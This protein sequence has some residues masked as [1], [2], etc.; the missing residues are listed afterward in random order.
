[1]DKISDLH[2]PIREYIINEILENYI[3]TKILNEKSKLESKI[4][5]ID[6]DEN[7]SEYNKYINELTEINENIK[8]IDKNKSK[9]YNNLT[10]RRIV[11]NIN[12]ANEVITKSKESFN[13][14]IKN[15]VELLTNNNEESD[16]VIQHLK[17]VKNKLG[18]FISIVPD[19]SNNKDDDVKDDTNSAKDEIDNIENELDDLKYHDSYDDIDLLEQSLNK[20]KEHNN[21]DI[22][23][24]ANILLRKLNK[25]KKN[26]K[27]K[28]NKKSEK[29]IK[30]NDSDSSLN[31]NPDNPDNPDNRDINRMSGGNSVFYRNTLKLL[32]SGGAPGDNYDEQKKFAENEFRKMN[33][34]EESIS[35][36]SSKQLLQDKYDDSDM[37]SDMDRD[38]NMD[39]DSDVDSDM[40]N[41]SD[42]DTD[43]DKDKDTDNDNDKDNDKDTDKDKDNDKDKDKDNDN[44]KDKEQKKEK[45]Y[46]KKPKKKKIN[47]VSDNSEISTD[48]SSEEKNKIILQLQEI[49]NKLT[50]N[51]KYIT[52]LYE[53]PETGLIS[54]VKELKNNL[55]E[56]DFY[57]TFKPYNDDASV[58]ISYIEEENAKLNTEYE[59]INTKI[60]GKIFNENDGILNLI[61]NIELYF[62]E[63]KKIILNDNNILIVIYENDNNKKMQAIHDIDDIIVK[64]DNKFRK[65]INNYYQN[66]KDIESVLKKLVKK[67]ESILSETKNAYEKIN[68]QRDEKLEKNSQRQYSSSPDSVD[69]HRNRWGGGRSR[70][71]FEIESEKIKADSK[72]EKK[73][74]INSTL[75]VLT[76][77]FKN[78]ENSIHNIQSKLNIE[79]NVFDNYKYNI[80]DTLYKKITHIENRL[81]NKSTDSNEVNYVT[82]DGNQINFNELK[83]DNIFSRIFNKYTNNNI[84]KNKTQQEND[85]DF[86]N[87]VKVN[88]LNPENVLEI[89]NTDKVIFIVLIFIIRQL[90]LLTV[91]FLLDYDFI[92]SFNMLI[93]LFVVIY[94]VILVLFIILVNL[95]NYKMRILFNY[96]NLHINYYGISTH[97]FTFL[98]FI[99]II[100]IYLKN[101]DKKILE[102]SN[103]KLN[104][105][106]KSEYKYRLSTISLII[107]L[108]TSITDYLL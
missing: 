11:R 85:D 57:N 88:D 28:K 32:F 76:E 1:M 94:I 80:Y 10:Y 22:K 107:F 44:D 27:N 96:V 101:S 5:K 37:D 19:N 60:I 43:K 21:K 13:E 2:D 41:D 25:L 62:N 61:D 51:S 55:K 90:A 97:I 6:K 91:N 75:S 15:Y 23:S 65:N 68:K 105:E 33:L 29:D 47:I 30:K 86:Y 49:K 7:E 40:D 106:E 99:I 50:I 108:F 56:I 48:V 3:Y 12:G 70:D 45:K 93:I 58:Y 52:K 39:R 64:L 82:N 83:N 8:K 38:R 78:D 35:S 104:E 34:P 84:K 53:E 98:L 63:V 72:K 9:N 89:T 42:K 4:D 74:L 17:Y 81:T 20:L 95:D 92:K 18:S 46:K 31:D 73:Q 102:S 67:V 14:L 71:Q 24:R 69:Y 87:S 54:L 100:Y 79:K 66:I 103:T 77:L 36:L 59:Y 26:K 16:K